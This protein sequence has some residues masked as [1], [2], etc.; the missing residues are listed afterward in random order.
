[1]L[2]SYLAGE[3]HEDS[4]TGQ[5]SASACGMTLVH[6]YQEAAVPGPVAILPSALP[7]DTEDLLAQGLHL[8]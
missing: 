6:L 2:T 8:K 1:M 4:K 5:V 3:G 7:E